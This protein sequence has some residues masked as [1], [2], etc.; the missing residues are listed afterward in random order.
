M[1]VI[2]ETVRDGPQDFP[3]DLRDGPHSLVRPVGLVEGLKRNHPVQQQNE[4]KGSS[5]DFLAGEQEMVIMLP[6]HMC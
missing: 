6:A 4:P 3:S 2:D 5:V 1:H